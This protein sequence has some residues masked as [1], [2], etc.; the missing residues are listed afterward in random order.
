MQEQTKKRYFAYRCPECTGTVLSLMGNF[1]LSGDLLRLRCSCKK[2][3][4]DIKAEQHTKVH[5][6]VPCPICRKPH[7]YTIAKSLFLEK[8]IF[9]LG[10]P[11]SPDIAVA[12][13][14]EKEPLDTALAKEEEK[15]S[16]ILAAF[17]SETLRDV[18]PQ[19]MN[20]EEILPDPQIYDI[21]RFL[22]R[23]LEAE[24]AI[25]C[26]CGRGSYDFRFT[27]AGIQVVCPDCGASYEFDCPS[28]EVAKGYLDLSELRLK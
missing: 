17:E 11:Y 20:D 14:G 3:V 24:G 22:V 10:C 16:A 13:M 8:P 12:L 19:D 28:E 2:S 9:T 4:A 26:P 5:L 21:I 7:R 23:E 1:S 6:S 15:L 18:Q 27:D 25:T